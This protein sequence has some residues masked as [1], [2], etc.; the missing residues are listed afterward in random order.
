MFRVKIRKF[1]L[2]WQQG[3]C[4]PIFTYTVLLPVPDN[5]TLEPQITTL[6]YTELELWRFKILPLRE[7]DF[8]EFSQTVG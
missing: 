8:F 1:S 3:R 5:P 7:Y 2:P 6:S 4:E